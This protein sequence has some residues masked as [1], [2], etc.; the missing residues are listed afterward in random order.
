MFPDTVNFLFCLLLWCEWLCSQKNLAL[1]KSFSYGKWGFHKNPKR[2]DLIWSLNGA[3]VFP[4]QLN[5]RYPCV[6][7]IKK[8]EHEESPGFQ[9]FAV[10]FPLYIVRGT[11]VCR[12][13]SE[14]GHL[15]VA[16]GTGW[17]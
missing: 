5:V 10:F 13:H 16:R 1:R 2:C 11:G 8:G 4:F 14:V 9:N 12:T 6:F 7:R 15:V 17:G 3:K